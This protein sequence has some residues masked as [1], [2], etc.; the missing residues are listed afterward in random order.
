L[1]QGDGFLEAQV[2]GE[3]GLD[4]KVLVVVLLLLHQRLAASSHWCS[5]HSST[6]WWAKNGKENFPRDPT[7]QLPSNLKK[8]FRL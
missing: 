2:S 1:D 5:P 3:E 8:S 4:A 6:E 7:V